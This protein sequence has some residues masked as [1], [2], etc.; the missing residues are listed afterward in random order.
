MQI[1]TLGTSNYWKIERTG[2]RRNLCAK[3]AAL[4]NQ[5]PHILKY[6][7]LAKARENFEGRNDVN[8]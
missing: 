6:E 3:N 5:L 4:E 1:L 7:N 8:A 2:L